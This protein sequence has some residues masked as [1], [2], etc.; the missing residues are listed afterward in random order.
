MVIVGKLTSA[1]LS[2]SARQADNDDM[3]LDETCSSDREQTNMQRER[4]KRETQK[5]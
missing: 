1:T 5:Q 3:E 4:G 2:I